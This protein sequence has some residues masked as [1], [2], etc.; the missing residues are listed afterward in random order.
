MEYSL[1]NIALLVVG[2]GVA[3]AINVIGGGGSLVTIP[4]L[5]GLGLPP[6]T[7]NGTNRIGILIDDVASLFGLRKQAATGMQLGLKLSIPVMLGAIIGS[8]TSLYI[9]KG[10]HGDLIMNILLL[11]MIIGTCI[12]ML[13]SPNKW[14]STS[15]STLKQSVG[16]WKWIL[17]CIIGFY[18]GFIQ[19]GFTYLIL[20]VLVME[21]GTSLIKGDFIKLLLNFAIT[22]IALIIFWIAGEIE[23]MAGLIMGAGGIIGSLCSSWLVKRISPK[24]SLSI[25]YFI[26]AISAF[27]IILFRMIKI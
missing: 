10:V 8:I 19:A 12:S 7:A 17:I 20:V 25:L 18:G 23:F 24:A 22:P 21:M 14:K 16:F 5:L 1:L 11:A 9:F 26:L 4:I 27:Y 15:N 6:N 2:G 3:A 13:S